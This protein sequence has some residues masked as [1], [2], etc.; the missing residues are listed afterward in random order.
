MDGLAEGRGGKGPPERVKMRSFVDSMLQEVRS[1]YRARED[2]L[3]SAARSYKKRLQ[4][5]TKTHRALLIA[6]R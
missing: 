5:T 6:Y 1:S 4:R 2:Q 3:A